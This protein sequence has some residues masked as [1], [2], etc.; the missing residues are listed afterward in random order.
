MGE[1]QGSVP[2]PSLPS[3]SSQFCDWLLEPAERQDGETG[4]S[5]QE[6]NANAEVMWPD[7]GL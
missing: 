5:G 1:D 6:G 7:R 3:E 2:L 4:R